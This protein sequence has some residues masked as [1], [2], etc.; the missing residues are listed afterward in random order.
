MNPNCLLQHK[1]PYNVGF[2]DGPD[3]EESIHEKILALETS[4]PKFRAHCLSMF[5]IAIKEIFSDRGPVGPIA[6]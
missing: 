3:I 1:N 2:Y 4:Y 6:A 5:L